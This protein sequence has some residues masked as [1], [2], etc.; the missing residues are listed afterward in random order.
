[1]LQCNNTSGFAIEAPGRSACAS[2]AQTPFD[3][4]RAGENLRSSLLLLG[5]VTYEVDRFHGTQTIA[6]VAPVNRPGEHGCRGRRVANLAVDIE[7]KTAESLLGR[8]GR[9]LRTISSLHPLQLRNRHLARRAKGSGQRAV[10][11][12]VTKSLLDRGFTQSH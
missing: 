4:S 9:A 6:I 11:V 2:V 12:D 8:Q 5:H 10:A 7:D 3:R 1:L